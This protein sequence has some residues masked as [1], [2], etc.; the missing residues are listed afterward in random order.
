MRG[1]ESDGIKKMRDKACA[2]RTGGR[3]LFPLP[4]SGGCRRCHLALVNRRTC[5]VSQRAYERHPSPQ[6]YSQPL[7]HHL[8]LYPSSL[9]ISDQQLSDERLRPY[10]VLHRRYNNRAIRHSSL[11]G[12]I[13][14]A[15]TSANFLLG[16][17][18]AQQQPIE[19]QE[20]GSC[21][22]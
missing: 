21:R 4:L 16:P 17:L 3:A 2:G 9:Q 8:L 11:A 5:R 19:C 14:P 20:L 1:E 15:T 6:T 10:N 12:T 22:F 18:C 7:V 13:P